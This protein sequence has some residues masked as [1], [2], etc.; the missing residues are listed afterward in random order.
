VVNDRDLKEEL[1]LVEKQMLLVS[2]LKTDLESLYVELIK[3]RSLIFDNAIDNGYTSTMIKEV[4]G[5][6]TVI[7]GE[8]HE[9]INLV[10]KKLGVC[11]IYE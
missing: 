1:P 3:K 5:T 8:E 7:K 2:Y 9:L 11:F 6:L 4:R 10:K